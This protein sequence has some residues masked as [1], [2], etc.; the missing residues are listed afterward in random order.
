MRELGQEELWSFIP[1]VV[2]HSSQG[3][4]TR[5]GGSVQNKTCQGSGLQCPLDPSRVGTHPPDVPRGFLA[6]VLALRRVLLR[7]QVAFV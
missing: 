1:E 7:L 4:L 6:L 5:A 2:A 3:G